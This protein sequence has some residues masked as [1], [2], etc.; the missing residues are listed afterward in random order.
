MRNGL[1]LRGAFV[2]AGPGLAGHEEEREDPSCV[3]ENARGQAYDSVLA[4]QRRGPRDHPGRNRFNGAGNGSKRLSLRLRGL[5]CKL[6]PGR[7]AAERGGVYQIGRRGVGAS[8]HQRGHSGRSTLVQKKFTFTGYASH[9][10]PHSYRSVD[11]VWAHLTTK[12]GIPAGP[13]SYRKSSLSRG[14]PHTHPHSYRSNHHRRQ[15]HWVRASRGPRFTAHGLGWCAPH[16]PNQLRSMGGGRPYCQPFALRCRHL[17][18]LREDRPHHRTDCYRPRRSGRSGPG[19]LWTAL[20]L[21]QPEPRRTA[22]DTAARAQRHAGG[23]RGA[24]YCR[25]RFVARWIDAVHHRIP[26]PREERF[27]R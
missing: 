1:G 9:T 25:L 18:K 2:Q 20:A 12:E 11:A 5:L 17:P 15:V 14:T 6:P 3:C 13:H 22:V 27:L 23:A 24:V 8:D 10:R 26:R 16:L 4:R 21:D 19:Q 7:W